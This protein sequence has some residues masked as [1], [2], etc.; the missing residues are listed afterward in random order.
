VLT[1]A[2]TSSAA[3]P[4]AD[5]LHVCGRLLTRLASADPGRLLRGGAER[6]GLSRPGASLGWA[7]TVHGMFDASGS[8]APAVGDDDAV[9]V[10][11]DLTCRLGLPVR[12]VLCAAGIRRS[13]FYRRA[14]A[15]RAPRLADQQNPWRLAQASRTSKSWSTEI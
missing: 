8:F 7:G 12:D 11:M 4:G 2:L 10:V 5:F 13:T 9:P 1:V 14:A 3:A 15:G 6:P